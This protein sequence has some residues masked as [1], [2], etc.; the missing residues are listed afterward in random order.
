MSITR[1]ILLATGVRCA[2]T[3]LNRDGIDASDTSRSFSR[4]RCVF[5]ASREPHATLDSRFFFLVFAVTRKHTK[6]ERNAS[7]DT[8]PKFVSLAPT[9]DAHHRAYR[10]KTRA[11]ERHEMPSSRVSRPTRAMRFAMV[12]KRLEPAQSDD[13]FFLKGVRAL[14]RRLGTP[15]TKIKQSSIKIGHHRRLARCDRRKTKR[16]SVPRCASSSRRLC[17]RRRSVGR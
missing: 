3:A 7:D 14:R 5:R 4:V 12:L 17:R 9:F 13:C 16:A 1:A 10:T 15:H 6:S 2:Q 11:F 8:H